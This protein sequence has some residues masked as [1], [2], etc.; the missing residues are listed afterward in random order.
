MLQRAFSE[1]IVPFKHFPDFATLSSYRS[2]DFQVAAFEI[3]HSTTSVAV[4]KPDTLVWLVIDSV[5][6]C[7]VLQ[8]S[9][10]FT[11]ITVSEPQFVGK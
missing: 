7:K 1:H 10:R 11:Q 6:R 9:S 4:R 5:E 8:L 2:A 3:Q